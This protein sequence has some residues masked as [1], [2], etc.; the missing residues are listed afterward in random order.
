MAFEDT[1]TAWRLSYAAATRQ[2]GRV[3]PACLRAVPS[4]T[5]RT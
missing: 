1:R 5:L 4:L 3:S 2:T